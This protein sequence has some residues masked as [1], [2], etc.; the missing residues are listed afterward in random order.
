MSENNTVAQWGD[1]IFIQYKGNDDYEI[2]RSDK[3]TSRQAETIA[4]IAL[5]IMAYRNSNKKDEL[6][7]ASN[8]LALLVIQFNTD[9]STLANIPKELFMIDSIGIFNCFSV[10]KMCFI[11]EPILLSDSFKG[12]F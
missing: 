6:N 5:R 11:K 10:E 3:L 4:K 7:I 2:R 12:M 1:N 9:L 8:V